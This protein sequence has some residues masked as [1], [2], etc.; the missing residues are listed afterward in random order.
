MPRR[1]KGRQECYG[2]KNIMTLTCYTLCQSGRCS[3]EDQVGCSEATVE[4]LVQCGLLP[5]KA[6]PLHT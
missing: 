5:T 1:K 4:R 3:E 2:R 6:E